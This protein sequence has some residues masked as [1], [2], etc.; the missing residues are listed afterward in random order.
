V[1]NISFS[2]FNSTIFFFSSDIILF[3]AAELT[4]VISL[5]L[6]CPVYVGVKFARNSLI[7]FL[8]GSELTSVSLLIKT[9]NAIN[10]TKSLIRF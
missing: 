6:S 9:I 1:R 10:E 5:L 7:A 3:R 4:V 2:M 8:V